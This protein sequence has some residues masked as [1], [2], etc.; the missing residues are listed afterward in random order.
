MGRAKKRKLHHATDEDGLDTAPHVG[1]GATLALLQNPDLPPAGQ[2][3][4]AESSRHTKILRT[5]TSNGQ[6]PSDSA[7]WQTLLDRTHIKDSEISQSSAKYP[8]LKHASSARLQ[9]KIKISDLQALVL[10]L[11]ADSTAPSWIAVENRRAIS[12]VV[13]VMLP[14]LETALF[15]GRIP[16]EAISHTNITGSGHDNEANHSQDVR[17][18]SSALSREKDSDQVNTKPGKPRSPDDYYPTELVKADLPEPLKPLADIFTHL[19]PVSTPGTDKFL[20]MQSPIQAMLTSPIPVSRDAKNRK[21]PKPPRG[22]DTWKDKPTPI[23]AFLAT[24]ED[25]RD[26]EFVLHPALCISEGDRL[27]ESEKQEILRARPTDGWKDTNVSSSKAERPPSHEA[28]NESRTAGRW[29]GN[30]VLDKLVKPSR[31]V[32]DYLTPYSGV[33]EKMLH[34]VTT[35]LEDVQQDLV[36][37]LQPDAILIGHSLNADLTALKMT[38]PYIVDT[39]IIY[40]HPVGPPLKSK[41]KFL[42]QKYLNREIQKGHGTVGHNSIEDARAVLD[43]VKQ[44]CD[45]GPLWGTSEASVESIFKRL[46]RSGQ[47]SKAVTTARRSGP[48]VDSQEHDFSFSSKGEVASV[49]ERSEGVDS[50]VVDWGEPRRGH[51]AAATYV[52]GCQGDDAVVKALDVA[53]NGDREGKLVAGSGSALTWCRLRELEALRGWWNNNRGAGVPPKKG[54]TANGSSDGAVDSS[55]AASPSLGELSSAVGTSVDRIS[56]MYESLPPCTAFIVYSGSGDPR[57]MGRLQGLQQQ[58][59]REFQSKKWDE[60]S[61]KWTDV[62]EQQLRAAV[63][64]ARNGLALITVK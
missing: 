43:L 34:S 32:I 13:I 53:V 39:S 45:K 42:A 9:T 5:E 44:K 60:L 61:V 23:N 26:N 30:V 62:E 8:S 12:K 29:D 6:H 35:T 50:A 36:A 48:H 27:A 16:M 46:D 41:L 25:L 24:A 54:D 17:D 28:A 51:G 52:F 58:F 31:P 19:W 64:A 14:G 10:Y 22:G 38:H 20:R 47:V 40:P 55:D 57:E 59:R 15:D 21:G 7:H 18:S 37:L 56:R 11:L 3:S 63:K 4:E 1:L 33:T 49:E 2:G